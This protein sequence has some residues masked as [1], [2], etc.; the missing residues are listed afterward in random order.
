MQDP[1]LIRNFCIIAHID[2]GKS[3]LADRLIETTGTLTQ[4]EMTAQV[5]D[6]MDIEKER[7]ITI[8]AQTAS[9]RY[10]AKDG[11][12]YLLNLIDTPGHVDFSYEVSRSLAACEGALLVVDAAQGVEAQTVA[13]VYMAV[14]S[15]LEIIPV[16]NK[17]DLPSADPDAVMIQIEEELGI[18]SS[19]AVKAS[20]KSGIGIVDILE[21]I[22]KIIPPPPNRND[23]TLRALIF[24]SWFDQYLGAVSLIRV[25][26][27][28]ISKGMRMQILSTG[29]SF[30]VLKVAQLSPKSIDVAALTSGMVGIVSGSIKSVRETKVGDTI[31][32]ANN[33]CTEGLT[34][35]K[36]A[37]QMVFG[38]IFPVDSSEYLNL[39][40]SL[41]KLIMNDSSLTTEP[42]VS[43]ALGFG[44]RVGF[45]GLLHMDIIQERLERE[46]N[47]DLIFTAPTVL[48][49]VKTD[50]GEIV[51][52]E[53]PS[54]LPEPNHITEIEE[55]YVKMVIH[56]PE[57]YIGSIMKILQEKRGQQ[58]DLEYSNAKKVKIIYEMPMNEM[59]F[60]FHDKLKS[61]SRGYASMDYEVI[62]YRP[63][64]LVKVDIM[65]N[66]DKVDALACINHRSTADNR[67]RA[68]CKKLKELLPRQMF[69]V[70]LQAAIGSKIIARETISAMRKDVTAKC[71]GGDISRKRKLLEKQKE[72]KKRM[73]QIGNVEI[74]QTAFL[75]ILSLDDD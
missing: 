51:T 65:V 49:K 7:G 38:G 52:V 54:K 64:D 56:T 21:A 55:P 69:Q 70:A 22:V 2:H 43:Q 32:D 30:E 44:F 18:D 29:N 6:S 63:G 75:A 9:M 45:L 42:E 35:F 62:D 23:E 13:N 16:I 14:E 46:Y 31:T 12:T 59:I 48:Y 4:R 53:N 19:N 37:K 68:I 25:M 36:E 71:Y 1:K 26:S 50:K 40:D 67:G 10:T 61:I 33:P 8:K 5:L 27:G 47:L 24:D 57:E 20:A 41:E 34:G 39:K 15:N 28:S 73:K 17:I 60:D 3:T 11:R 72:G 58:K 74:P 66:G